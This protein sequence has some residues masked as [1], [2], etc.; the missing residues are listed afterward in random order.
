MAKKNTPSEFNKFLFM[1]FA[2][3]KDYKKSVI[4]KIIGWMAGLKKAL[5]TKT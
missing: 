4:F 1:M 5:I 2:L 3:T